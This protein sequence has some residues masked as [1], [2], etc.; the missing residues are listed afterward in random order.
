MPITNIEFINYSDGQDIS[1]DK[2]NHNFDEVVE[3]HGGSI[4]ETG[5]SG[6]RGPIGANGQIGPTGNQGQRGTRWFIQGGLPSGSG[7][8]VI[9]GDYWVDSDDGTINI[10]GPSGWTDTG[11]NL[12]A[13]GSLFSD[14]ESNFTNGGTGVSVRLDQITP[15]NYTFIISDKSPQSGIINEKNM[16]ELFS[17]YLDNRTQSST[18]SNSHS[19]R[20]HAIFIIQ[21]SRFKIGVVDLAGSERFAKNQ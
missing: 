4:G 12:S 18:S 8:S 7:D 15:E 3:Y 6:D 10:F 5:P 2:L 9:Y 13:S 14:I 11:Y 19:S 16:E 21:T 20:S 1:I 17:S